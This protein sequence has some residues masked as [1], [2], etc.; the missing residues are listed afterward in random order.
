M[1]KRL[2]GRGVSLKRRIFLNAE[3]ILMTP[4]VLKWRKQRM[5]G[6]PL[7]QF[8]AEVERLEARRT[9]SVSR[10]ERRKRVRFQVHWPICFLGIDS[11]G[12]IETVTENLSSSGFRCSSPVPLTVGD[13]LICMLR[14]PSHQFPHNGR[15]LFLECKVRVIRVEPA[16]ERRSYRVAC[17][18]D[19][20]RFIESQLPV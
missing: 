2:T 7:E 14:L 12:T 15:G 17:Q 11:G 5:L 1:I 19:D 3:A 20:Y 6:H 8:S 10:P 16:E 4:K 9:Q 13:Q 18:I